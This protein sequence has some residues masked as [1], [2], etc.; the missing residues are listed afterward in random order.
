MDLA[1][2]LARTSGDGMTPVAGTSPEQPTP[3]AVL[4]SVWAKDAQPPPET[5][6]WLPPQMV[7]NLHGKKR[8]RA[9]PKP[10]DF[11][12]M[13]NSNNIV[14]RR[15]FLLKEVPRKQE[16]DVKRYCE[17]FGPVQRFDCSAKGVYDVIWYKTPALPLRD[18]GILMVPQVGRIFVELNDKQID[19]A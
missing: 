15:R 16:N 4:S 19:F 18:F 9:S 11:R 3:L 1:D 5:L 8:K 17:T 10:A 2:N 7:R 6:V 14:G 12:R 13:A